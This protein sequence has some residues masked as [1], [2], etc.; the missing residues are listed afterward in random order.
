M[1]IGSLILSEWFIESK[2][3]KSF[4]HQSEFICSL[5]TDCK[6]ELYP[7]PPPPGEWGG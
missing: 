4:F 2:K 5:A 7:P 1:N 3:K 6:K